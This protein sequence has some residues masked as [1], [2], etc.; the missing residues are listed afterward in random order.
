M[1]VDYSKTCSFTQAI[2]ATF[3]GDHPCSL[4][5]AVQEGKK[6]EKHSEKFSPQKPDLICVAARPSFQPVF[7]VFKYAQFDALALSFADPPGLPP[8]RCG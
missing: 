1:I 3:D 7:V 4:C 8:P 6:S 5:H 2:S